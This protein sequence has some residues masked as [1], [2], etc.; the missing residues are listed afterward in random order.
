VV[1]K[2]TLRRLR[3]LEQRC[4]SESFDARNESGARERILEK[5]NAMADPRRG[6]PDWELMP[7][8]TT[9]ELRERIQKAAS[10]CRGEAVG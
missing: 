6:N 2:A 7:E 10:G 4:C 9:A 1:L 8:P 3:Q 5:I